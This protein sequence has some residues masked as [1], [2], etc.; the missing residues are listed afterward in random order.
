MEFSAKLAYSDVDEP[1]K[2]SDWKF[3]QRVDNQTRPLICTFTGQHSP[4]K[5]V[6]FFLLLKTKQTF[7]ILQLSFFLTIVFILKSLK[8][9]IIKNNNGKLWTSLQ[10]KIK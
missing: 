4:A 9:W 6:T 2:E 1:T 8:I 5:D 3:L 10:I 7:F